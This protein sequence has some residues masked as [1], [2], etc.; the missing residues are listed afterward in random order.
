MHYHIKR[1]KTKWLLTENTI[2]ST[3]FTKKSIS[4]Q[5]IGGFQTH[6]KNPE[7]GQKLPKTGQ[8]FPKIAENLAFWNIQ[9]RQ[10]TFWR[11]TIL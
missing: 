2:L 7:I 11:S 9:D 1:G 5:K 4:G 3:F 8:K 10:I 6:Q